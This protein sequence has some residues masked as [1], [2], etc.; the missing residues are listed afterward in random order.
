MKAEVEKRMERGEPIEEDL[1]DL[2]SL[3][4]DYFIQNEN[5]GDKQIV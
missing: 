5:G 1:E 3:V 2:R 4:C